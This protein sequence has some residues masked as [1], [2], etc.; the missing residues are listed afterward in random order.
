[1]QVIEDPAFNEIHIEFTST[2]VLG[3]ACNDKYLPIERDTLSGA[4][5]FICG[6]GSLTVPAARKQNRCGSD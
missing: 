2:N 6:R 4:F 3:S 1:M 5:P